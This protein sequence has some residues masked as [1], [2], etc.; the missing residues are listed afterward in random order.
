MAFTPPGYFRLSINGFLAAPEGEKPWREEYFVRVHTIGDEL[1]FP[2]LRLRIRNS[3]RHDG[4]LT[5]LLE[6]AAHSELTDLTATSVQQ[7]TAEEMPA[8]DGKK[9]TLEGN[10]VWLGDRLP[11]PLG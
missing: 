2:G 1:D 3:D 9:G 11:V 8:S 6:A 7:I 5:A 4:P 10:H